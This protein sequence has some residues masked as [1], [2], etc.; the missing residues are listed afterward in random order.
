MRVPLLAF[1]FVAS[2][3]AQSPSK[4]P[5]RPLAVGIFMQFDSLPGSASLAAMERE[6]EEIMKPSGLALDWLLAKDNRGDRPFGGLVFLRFKGSCKA[7]SFQPVNAF[8]SAGDVR[9]LGSTA[10]SEGRV[11]PFTEVQ[12]DQVR[13]ALAYLRPA[14]GFAERQSAL[15]RALGRVVAHELYHIFART[16]GHSAGGLAGPEQSLEDLVSDRE[17]RFQRKDAQ[18]IGR[19]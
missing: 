3:L 16:T 15:G 6:V 4:A 9:A 14:T 5:G 11:L 7:D 8:G 17:L 10:V 1:V 12:C 13:R 18:A 2:A 19:K